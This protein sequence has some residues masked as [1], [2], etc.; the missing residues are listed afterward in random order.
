MISRQ[1]GPL[2]H[3]NEKHKDVSEQFLMLGTHGFL[4]EEVLQIAVEDMSIPCAGSI[5]ETSWK[6]SAGHS[7][8]QQNSSADADK[9][10]SKKT[11]DQDGAGTDKNWKKAG[12]VSNTEYGY[13]R[14]KAGLSP[15]VLPITN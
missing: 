4:G 8:S 14:T 13:Q 1:F 12:H 9:P 2:S 6:N 3:F 15:A 7:Q 11:S 10:D 5:V